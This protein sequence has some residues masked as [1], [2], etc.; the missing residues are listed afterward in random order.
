MFYFFHFFYS[1]SPCSLS[2]SLSTSILSSSHLS[3]ALTSLKLSSSLSPSHLKLTISQAQALRLTPSQPK[4]DPLSSQSPI[5]LDPPTDPSPKPPLGFIVDPSS[6]FHRR[7]RR[8]L[9]HRGFFCRS[10]LWGF[11]FFFF[12]LWT[13]GGCGWGKR[14]EI[15]VFF[16]FFSLLWTGGGGGCGYGWW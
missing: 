8:C 7:S 9:P 2:S 14:L 11:F 1:I 3:Q 4:L 15:W 10:K 12:L 16:F 6:R 13:G 5:T